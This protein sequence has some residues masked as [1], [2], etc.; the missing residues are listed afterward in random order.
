MVMKSINVPT[1]IAISIISWVMV[2]MLHEIA[3][4]AGLAYLSGLKVNAVN[5]TTAYLQ[6]NWEK[7]VANN[8]FDRL[9]LFLIGGV[10]LNFISGFIGYLVLRYNHSLKPEMRL[11]LWYFTS[12][13]YIVIVMNLLTAPLTGGG[14]LAEIINTLENKRFA[15]YLVLITGMIFMILGY[16]IIQRAFMVKIKRSKVLAL[17]FIPVTVIIIIQ[18][19]S[20]LKSPFAYL[21]AAEN[22]LL[23]SFHF[24]IWAIIVNIIPLP[25][26]KHPTETILP[27]KSVP[28]LISGVII[29]LFYIFILGPGI[30]SF[31]GH[32]G[33]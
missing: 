1:M 22:H 2:N 4:H 29:A 15:R 9:R 6:V 23:A 18:S 12:F 25:G 13:S 31:E 17:T 27:G 20:L 10:L 7:E 3:G 5:T 14:D 33:L 19:L 26:K 32:P 16:L 11:F 8:G 28:W 24:L 30:G 21:P